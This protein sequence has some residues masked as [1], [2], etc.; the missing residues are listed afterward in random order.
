MTLLSLVAKGGWIMIF[1]GIASVVGLWAYVERLLSFSR[2]KINVEALM[3]QARGYV[4]QGRLAEAI[5]KFEKYPSPA[6]RVVVS[7]LRAGGKDKAIIREAVE[8]EANR[9]VRV[10]ESKTTILATV[11]AVAP[12]MGF[13]GTVTGMIT[14]FH[15]IESLQG[16]V[17]A[18]VLA[19]GIKEALVTTAAG[20]IVGIPAIVGYN[21]IS[22]MIQKMV[23]EMEDVGGEMI[24]M[25]S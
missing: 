9:Q 14:A 23:G 16:N 19:G 25:L 2:L 1:I 3:Q 5:Q 15:Q 8:N 20:L 24:V 22:A 18:S 10:L 4:E 11:A 12:L 13:L 17:D 6:A 21:H 7:A